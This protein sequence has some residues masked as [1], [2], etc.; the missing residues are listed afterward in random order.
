MIDQSLTCLPS[1]SVITRFRKRIQCIPGLREVIPHQ[2]LRFFSLGTCPCTSQVEQTMTVPMQHRSGSS[3]L[4]YSLDGASP[5][6]VYTSSQ[7]LLRDYPA[8]ASATS[9]S[10]TLINFGHV[11]PLRSGPGMKVLQNPRIN[12]RHHRP[13]FPCTLENVNP[14]SD[15]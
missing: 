14:H 11:A 6:G 15:V 2:N 3:K 10:S 1:D 12:S 7:R 13:M 8:V 9:F 5:D 4:T